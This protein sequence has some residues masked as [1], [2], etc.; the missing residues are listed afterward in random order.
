MPAYSDPQSLWTVLIY[1]RPLFGCLVQT[2]LN[3]LLPP[4][5]YIPSISVRFLE[6]LS[7][8]SQLPFFPS[9]V[10][11]IACYDIFF[12]FYCQPISQQSHFC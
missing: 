7:P 9:L 2:G 12:T 11:T 3:I 4:P 8:G 1:V 6:F 5:L 10:V